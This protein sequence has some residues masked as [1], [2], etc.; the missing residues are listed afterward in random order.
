MTLFEVYKQALTKLQN[1]DVEEINIRILLAEVNILNSMSDFY[2][3]KDEEI[4]DL[5]RFQ[6]YFDR[7]IKGEPIQYI[8]GKT[9][10]LGL[11]IK[12]DNRVLIPRQ[13]SEE[14]VDF[15]IKKAH[16]LFGNKTPDL[17]DVCCG[18]GVMGI[19][20]SKNLFS[21]KVIFSDISEDALEVCEENCSNNGVKGDFYLG[22]GLDEL[23]KNNEKVDILIS[24]PPYILKSEPVDK[25]VLDY[26][27]H[28]ALFAD[29]EFSVY[30]SIISKLHLVKKGLLLAVFELGINSKDKVKNMINRYYPDCEYGF[31]KDINGKERILYIVLR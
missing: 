2:L 8:L 30:E 28:L 3:R 11:E 26:E 7:Y 18:S 4:R 29:S 5:P 21:N 17:V 16:E 24:N 1:P 13:E 23:I 27:P 20:L 6:S 22:N 31:I 9:D 10:F 25:S 15:T 12:V 19:A 14:V